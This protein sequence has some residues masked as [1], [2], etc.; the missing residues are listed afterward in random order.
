M[1]ERALILLLALVAAPLT[2][3]AQQAGKV[4]RIGIL[5][6]SS[7]A[8]LLG[9]FEA[10][11]QALRDL[12]YVE[13]QNVILD[14]RG[15]ERYER[16]PRLSAELVS[17]RP[18]VIVA[19][20]SR[21]ATVARKATETIPIV[22]VSVGD[23]IGIGLFSSLARPGGN[24]T[25]LSSLGID[26]T[27]KRLQ[28]LKEMHPRVSRVAVLLHSQNPTHPRALAIAQHAAPALGLSIQTVEVRGADHLQDALAAIPG[29]RVEALLPL[30]DGMFVASRASI[31]AVAL[32]NRLPLIGNRKAWVADGALISYGVD[33][34]EHWRLAARYVDRIL[35]GAKPAD[36]PIEEPT[37][38]E[39]AINLKTAKALGL[40]I[41]H[42]ILL[43]TDQLIE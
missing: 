34:S 3:E 2:A 30:P 25:G 13:G 6:P 39:L 8:A 41:P 9:G 14:V 11:G 15:S 16:L 27:A 10:F 32:T 19:Y 22:M 17:L 29:Q 1:I 35:K 28:L 43:R 37:K 23:P 7:D 36:L 18:D 26:L 31:I 40:A 5:L 4:S 12:G 24:I 38:L 21:P 33:L 20:S 42:S